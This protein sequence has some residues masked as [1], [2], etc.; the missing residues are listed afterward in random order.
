[1]CAREGGGGERVCVYFWLGRGVVSA[2]E[3]QGRMGR[4]SGGQIKDPTSFPPSFPRGGGTSSRRAPWPSA[5]P[6]VWGAVKRI[7]RADVG[8]R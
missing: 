4:G 5:A 6:R 2:A 7:C 8:C 1:M 3:L